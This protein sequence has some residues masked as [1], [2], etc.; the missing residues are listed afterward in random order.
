MTVPALATRLYWNAF[1]LWQARGERKL[2]YRPLAE[3]LEL[4]SRRVQAMVAHAY[5]HVPFY[6]DAMDQRGLKPGDF[7]TAADLAKL[8]LIDARIYFEE[9]PRFQADNFAPRALRL[10]LD[11][12]GTSG[13]AKQLRYEARALFLA[14]AQGHRQRIVYSRFSGK[15]L[16]IP[17]D[18]I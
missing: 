17:G 12:S 4:Q 11:S 13:R 18:E 6:R 7:Q 16:N 1:T 10:N 2:P 5:R 3:I 9:Q 14:M 15:L 8:P